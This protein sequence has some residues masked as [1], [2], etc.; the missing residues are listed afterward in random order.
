MSKEIETVICGVCESQ[1][2]IV[3]DP[4][5]TSGYRKFCSF[6]GEIDDVKDEVEDDMDYDNE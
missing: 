1:Y 6:C 5:E 3:Y 4:N 2:K